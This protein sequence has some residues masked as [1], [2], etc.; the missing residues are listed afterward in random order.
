MFVF[1]YLA[2]M[3]RQRRRRF[4]Q[5]KQGARGNQKAIGVIR[6]NKIVSSSK[7]FD[8]DL[9]RRGV[10]LASG[11][12]WACISLINR[13]FSTRS[14]VYR[15]YR[16]TLDSSSIIRRL[17]GCVLCR[18]ISRK[19]LMVKDNGASLQIFNKLDKKDSS[20]DKLKSG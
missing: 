12:Q 6:I 11:G 13:I 1:I 8:D 14:V 16:Y 19:K 9:V 7:V 17:R 20:H 2:R 5:Q 3:R 18:K 4:I 15:Y 10:V